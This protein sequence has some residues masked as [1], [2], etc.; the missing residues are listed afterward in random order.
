MKLKIISVGREKADQSAPLVDDY[1]ARIRKFVPVN[2]VILRP[3]QEGRLLDKITRESP[4]LLVALDER[5]EEFTSREFAKLMA[6]WMDRG[7]KTVVLVIGGA[8]G[9]P[10]DVLARANKKIALL[11]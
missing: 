11:S 1:I 6:S 8:N 4:S 7:Q 5:G 10:K 2:D 9:L 3:T